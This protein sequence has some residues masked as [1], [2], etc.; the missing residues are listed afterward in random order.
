MSQ[1]SINKKSA[2]VKTCGGQYVESLFLVEGDDN[3]ITM[4]YTFLLRFH[5]PQRFDT[6]KHFC[7]SFLNFAKYYLHNSVVILNIKYYI[8]NC[9]HNAYNLKCLLETDWQKWFNDVK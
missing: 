4:N 9:S 8:M 6:S 7:C 2:S 3:L 5:S 1:S